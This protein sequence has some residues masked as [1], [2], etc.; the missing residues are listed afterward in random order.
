MYC[1][2]I[3]YSKKEETDLIVHSA[4]TSLLVLSLWVRNIKHKMEWL[5]LMHIYYQKQVVYNS[6]FQLSQLE[7]EN[8][9]KQ[10]RDAYK[11]FQAFE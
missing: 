3:G 7:T 4:V 9:G 8:R 1:K 5:H 6:T 11:E 10:G 2:A